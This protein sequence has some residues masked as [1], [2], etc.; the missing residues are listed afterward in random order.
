VTTLTV[1][2]LDQQTTVV[3]ARY[4]YELR[5]GSAA[6]AGSLDT[7]YS[8]DVSRALVAEWCGGI[9]RALTAAA[10]PVPELRR[11]GQLLYNQL[12]PAAKRDL[13]QLGARLFDS[14][15]PVLIRTNDQTVPWELL[16][17]GS[18]FLGLHRDLGRQWIVQGQ[19]V[20][21]RVIGSI[22]RALIIGDTLDNL[23]AARTEAGQVAKWLRTRGVDCTVLLGED[24]TLAN[25]VEKLA[26]S[27]QPY[28]L[29][30]FC[31]H[32][33]A[34]T[35]PPGLTMHRRDLLD[36]V[37][38]GTL[39]RGVPPVVFINGCASAG[40]V[41]N[42]CRSFMMMGAQS[43]IGTR[44]DVVDGSAWHFAEHFYDRLLA[45]EPVGSA[46]RAAR[47]RLHDQQDG[48]WAAFVLYGAPSARFAGGSEPAPAPEKST[49][50]PLSPPVL[51]LLGRVAMSCRG[52]VI[53][54]VDLLLGLLHSPDLQQRVKANI[55][56]E[57]QAA[58]LEL[59]Q[60]YLER[61]RGDEEDP[62]GPDGTEDRETVVLSGTVDRIMNEAL[63]DAL[64]RGD[65]QVSTDD[66]A[67]AF[68]QVGG[69]TSARLLE[70]CGVDPGQLF[71]PD[72][73]GTQDIAVTTVGVP[74]TAGERSPLDE[75]SREVADALCV[76]QSLALAK[77]QIIGSHTLL[78]AFAALDS[79]V[80]RQAL[81]EQGTDT[82]F[83]FRRFRRR[84]RP[85][86]RDLSPRV[87]AALDRAREDGP[88][89]VGEA[90]MLRALFTDEDSSAREVLRRLGVDPERLIRS[91]SEA[92]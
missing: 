27:E 76:A 63:S 91:L 52:R 62:D 28:D 78:F 51:A 85:E 72:P 69:G 60:L 86:Q 1:R 80:L 66:V 57:R 18:G 13:P 34:S 30:H 37:A 82:R 84:V 89:P 49:D 65:T 31:G 41:A 17:N 33:S 58:A 32:A 68:V 50:Q 64:S 35:D 10:D 36:E 21:G 20:S 38:L 59:L 14:P 4:V 88:G 47:R 3:N 23:P 6:Q 22:G 70:L 40:R 48:T 87:R 11:L 81:A 16:H 19:P 12:F 44:T 45:H 26:S 55:G 56:A 67:A 75:L 25:V 71:R 29:F 8:V 77:G 92:D 61:A 9:D 43:V 42:L 83:A 7:E 15:E 74:A 2:V 39:A 53:T 24:A 79:E 90:A 5:P 46:I 54:S 73:P